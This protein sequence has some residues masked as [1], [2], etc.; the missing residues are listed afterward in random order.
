[1]NWYRFTDK[2][3]GTGNISEQGLRIFPNPVSGELSIDI[4]GDRGHKMTLFFRAMNG[5]LVKTLDLQGGGDLQ[6]A[7][8]GDLPKGFYLLEAE[9]SGTVYHAKLIV[10]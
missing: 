6:K 5:I 8:V 2:S 7:Y 4:P 1:M 3:Q 9:V 10:Q